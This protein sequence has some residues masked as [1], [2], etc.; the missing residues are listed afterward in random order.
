MNEYRFDVFISHNSKD[1]PAVRELVKK[2]KLRNIKYW[3]DEERIMPGDSNIKKLEEGIENSKTA[4]VLIGKDGLG[5]WEIPEMEACLHLAN[6]EGKLV[7]P[8]LLPGVP[9]KPKLPLL[10]RRFSWVDLRS[11]LNTNDFE[12]F[13]QA[14]GCNT[15]SAPP[16]LPSPILKIIALS[17]MGLSLMLVVVFFVSQSPPV[18]M[19]TPDPQPIEP[20]PIP[21][22]D[23]QPIELATIPVP[24][25][26][27]IADVSS[28]KLVTLKVDPANA[29]LLIS[30][31]NSD[32]FLCNSPCELNQP[33]GTRIHYK[34]TLTGYDDKEGDLSVN[35]DPPDVINLEKS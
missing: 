11:G 20:A 33:I 5:P 8:V 15:I 32:P 7:M 24:N 3:L 13:V 27:P 19:P 1:K 10:L 14:I 12:R 25:P 34:A 4:A 30:I 28:K 22:P 26:Q 6:E 29:D 2:L 17:G 9:V 18:S 16:P 21:V 23:P 35:V 31:N